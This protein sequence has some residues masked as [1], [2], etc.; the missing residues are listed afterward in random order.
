MGCCNSKEAL[1]EPPIV[2][3]GSSLLA[4]AAPVYTPSESAATPT[5]IAEVSTSR[6][7]LLGQTG[8][9]RPLTDDAP[10]KEASPAA[11]SAASPALSAAAPSTEKSI[12][13]PAATSEPAKAASADP[14][15]AS[16]FTKTEKSAEKPAS[17][18]EKTASPFSK[19]DRSAAADKP[20]A[21]VQV[22]VSDAAS[23]SS[24]PFRKTLRRQA[25]D[26]AAHLAA[27]PTSTSRSASPTYGWNMTASEGAAALS[28]A[29]PHTSVTRASHPPKPDAESE[30]IAEPASGDGP[31]STPCLRICVEYIEDKHML[32]VYVDEAANLGGAHDYYAK[33]YMLPDARPT[34][35]RKSAVIKKTSA[36]KFGEVFDYHVTRDQLDDRNLQISSTNEEEG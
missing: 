14:A 12:A 8:A 19:T 5:T 4:N 15:K 23:D 33:L 21:A 2:N 28:A 18:P 6:A 11:I 30:A 35:K 13:L 1:D 25:A 3:E 34:T 20:A 16:P 36:P 24:N 10:A 27:P 31:L 17:S 32:R 29:V 7:P 26:D 9:K 22:T